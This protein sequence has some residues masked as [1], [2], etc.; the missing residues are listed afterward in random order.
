MRRVLDDVAGHFVFDGKP[1]HARARPVDGDEAVG[2]AF[3]FDEVVR[4]VAHA[5][6]REAHARVGQRLAVI[7]GAEFGGFARVEFVRVGQVFEI[8]PLG[9]R[10]EHI[11]RRLAE[12]D[13]G[14]GIERQLFVFFALLVRHRVFFLVFF[15][16]A[17]PAHAFAAVVV[18]ELEIVQFVGEA[19]RALLGQLGVVAGA[20]FAG[21]QV[22]FFDFFAV[23]RVG[24]QVFCRTAAVVDVKGDIGGAVVDGDVVFFAGKLGGARTYPDVVRA[25]DAAGDEYE[26]GE[27]GAFHGKLLLRGDGEGDVAKFALAAGFGFCFFLDRQGE[28]NADR[29]NAA[30]FAHGFNHQGIAAVFEFGETRVVGLDFDVVFARFLRGAGDGIGQWLQAAAALAPPIAQFFQVFEAFLRVVVFALDEVPQAQVFDQ[31]FVAVFHP[32]GDVGAVVFVA[33]DVRDGDFYVEVRCLDAG[34][35][36]QRCGE[37]GFFHDFSCG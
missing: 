5:V 28:G 32:N 34:G 9:S 33:F 30:F 36:Q 13:E 1:V 7:N 31:L 14:L 25:G 6:F 22:F 8:Q 35:E 20:Q 4:A 3:E 21:H 29:F 11:C 18:V 27:M 17:A 12:G 2:V 16:A 37:E 15:R 19:V 23:W 10:L 24:V 26:R